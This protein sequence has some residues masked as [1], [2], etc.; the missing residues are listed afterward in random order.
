MIDGRGIY[1]ICDIKYS[2]L[3][4]LIDFFCGV[5]KCL[6]G[7]AHLIMV[8]VYNNVYTSSTLAAVF[9]DV[10]INTSPCSFAN[11]KPYK[12]YNSHYFHTSY[13]LHT[14]TLHVCIY[15]FARKHLHTQNVMSRLFSDDVVAV[16]YVDVH[17]SSALT[18]LLAS[19][20]LQ[21]MT[22]RM[23]PL[24]LHYL[25]VHVVVHSETTTT[26]DT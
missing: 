1:L 8:Y 11:A 9:A 21:E 20:S 15:T 26:T 18:S 7:K 25:T 10:S 5:D 13:K 12:I 3:N 23:K 6:Q 14:H 17:T 22:N 19:R 4:L 24:P 16:Y 2:I